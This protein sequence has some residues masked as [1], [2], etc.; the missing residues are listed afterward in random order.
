MP[1]FVLYVDKVQNDP[2]ASPS[3]FTVRLEVG[4]TGIPAEVI[5]GALKKTAFCDY[6][7]RK[8][9]TLIKEWRLEP[10]Q[11]S[12]GS[13]SGGRGGG[14]FSAPKGGDFNLYK[15]AQ[16]IFDRSALSFVEE[17]GTEY[18][19][20]RFTAVLPAAGRTILGR[21]AQDLLCTHL[22]R[23]IQNGLMYE[24]LDADAIEKHNRTILVQESLR[25]Q[26]EDYGLVAFIGNGSILPRASG[27]DPRPMTKDVIPF[28][29]PTSLE[30]TIDTGVLDSHGNTIKITGMGIKKGVNVITGGGFHGKTTLLESL[31]LGIYNVIP[32]D[33][34]ETIV[35]NPTAFKI[36]AEDGRSVINTNISPFINTLPGLRDTT[37]FTSADASGSTSMA[38]GIQEALECGATTFLIDEDTSATNFLIRDAKMQELIEAEPITPYISKVR[39]LFDTHGVS[40]IIVTGGCGDYLSVA[41]T[42][43]GMRNFSPEDWTS[44]AKSIIQKHPDTI[45]PIP[46]FGPI[47]NRTPTIPYSVVSRG[48]KAFGTRAIGLAGNGEKEDAEQ[49]DLDLVHLEQLVEGGQVVTIAGC[50]VGMAE[51]AEKVGGK[52]TFG[53]WVR[54]WER[55]FEK[56]VV[57]GEWDRKKSGERVRVRGLEI[58]GAVNRMRQVKVTQK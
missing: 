26:L 57:G 9:H 45:T 50:L 37:T 1:K 13:G 20:L 54:E 27:K 6:A 56:G 28:K 19:Q 22:P 5:D 34:R 43:I 16:Q 21:K 14:G 40:T 55:R 53:E 8:I 24:N 4:E 7:I 51:E 48:P 32:G 12:S 47:P 58:L 23:I 42:V 33:G 31:E 41:D 36:R 15:P 2:Y 52:R 3:K 17:N 10:A 25:R 29:S 38:A 30:V 35:T 11:Q 18:L 46:V 39:A 44:R 49:K